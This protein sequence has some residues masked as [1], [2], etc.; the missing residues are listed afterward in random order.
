MGVT[1]TIHNEGD[2]ARKHHRPGPV[3]LTAAA[4][5]RT[6]AK[7]EGFDATTFASIVVF[8]SGSLCFDDDSC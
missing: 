7:S 4:T 2:S 6:L 8:V 1:K 3:L 5:E